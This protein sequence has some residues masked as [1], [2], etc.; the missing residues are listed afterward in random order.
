MISDFIQQVVE[1]LEIDEAQAAKATGG[2]LN[3]IK[4]NA[5]DGDFQTLLSQLSGAEPLMVQAEAAV[6]SGGG[7][8]GLGGMI[9]G[10]L[11][12]A[13]GGGGGMLGNAAAM[14]SLL[15]ATEMNPGQL[16]ALAK[17]FLKY[18]KQHAGEELVDAMLAEMPEVRSFIA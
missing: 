8:G 5:K 14:M 11:G 18:V 2:I 10:A 1:K 9:G 7:S 3:I 12:S 6:K 15:S 17:M 4:K 16:K 13:L